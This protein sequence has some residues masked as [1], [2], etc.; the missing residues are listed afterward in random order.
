VTNLEE[1]KEMKSR[2]H[3]LA[4]ITYGDLKEAICSPADL[5]GARLC[6]SEFSAPSAVDAIMQK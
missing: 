4:E 5:H 6:L 3:L 1:A 2:I